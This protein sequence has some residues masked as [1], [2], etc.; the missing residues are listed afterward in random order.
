MVRKID[1]K[2]FTSLAKLK[3]LIEQV[4]TKAD[5]YLFTEDDKL[6]AILVSPTYLDGLIEKEVQDIIAEGREKNRA[7]H[8]VF[9]FI[10]ELREY[11][12]D[13]DPEEIQADINE[14]VK[15]VKRTQLEKN[16]VQIS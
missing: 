7:K 8:E 4:N 3:E 11:N 13:A 15:A 2:K 14:A 16:Q 1:L 12:K 10:R 6:L 5:Q 9:E